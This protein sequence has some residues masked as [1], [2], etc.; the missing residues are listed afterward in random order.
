MSS[1]PQRRS[2]ARFYRTGAVAHATHPHA[3]KHRRVGRPP[4]RPR[5]AGLVAALLEGNVCTICT[6]WHASRTRVECSRGP[7]GDSHGLFSLSCRRLRLCPRSTP[8]KV[9][10]SRPAGSLD[11]RKRP[12][13]AAHRNA[14]PAGDCDA[15]P[16]DRGA[17]ATS[18]MSA[19]DNTWQKPTN[20][21]IDTR[22]SVYLPV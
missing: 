10:F 5:G 2:P 13:R 9:G 6:A 21:R 16:P 17:Q 4:P 14:K 7:V 18:G 3:S 11:R 15:G 12:T 1:N 8:R 20:F 22:F 19:N